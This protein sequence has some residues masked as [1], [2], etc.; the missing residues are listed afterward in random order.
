MLLL[1]G[2][3]VVL[4]WITPC[5][6]ALAENFQTNVVSGVSVD[7]TGFDYVVGTS[8]SFNYFEINGGGSQTNDD[9]IVGDQSTASNNSVVIKDNNSLWQ[10]GGNLYVGNTGS[11][12]QVTIQ[13]GGRINCVLG[14]IGNDPAAASNKVVVSDANSLWSNSQTLT[15][16][17][18]GSCNQL[19]VTNGGRVTSASGVQSSV[20][21]NSSGAISNTVLLSGSN[22][23]WNCGGPLIV[24]NGGAGSRLTI[25]SGARVRNAD[26][27]I[28]RSSTSTNNVV[29]V[30]GA[31]SLWSNTGSLIVGVSG[32]GNAVT[33]QNGGMVSNVVGHL[34]FNSS[35]GTNTV[36][37]TDANSLWFTRDKLV[38]GN[39]GGGNQL[40]IT[41]SGLVRGTNVVVG[42]GSGGNHLD[43]L[44]GQLIV[45]N[46]SSKAT[47]SI[48]GGTVT[49]NGGTVTVDQ[50]I[51]T[52]VAVGPSIRTNM[53]VFSNGSL[54]TKGTVVTDGLPFIVGDGT[55]AATL[56]LLGGTHSFAN[57]LTISSNSLL[58][59]FG[60]IAANLTNAGAIS[61]GNPVGQLTI[62]GNFAQPSNAVLNFDLGGYTQGTQ[63]DYLNA[64]GAAA[65]AGQV[66]VSF[67]NGFGATITNGSSF[68][69]LT[70]GPVTGA[71]ANAPNGSRLQT[72][73][74]L[75]DFLVTYFG[76]AFVLS[77]YHDLRDSV[78]DGIPNWWRQQYFGSAMTTNS[79]SC[80]ACDP[81]GD[82]L[83]DLQEFLAGTDPNNGASSFRV[84][85]IVRTNNDVRISWMTG[86]GKTNALQWT[87]GDVSGS[88]NTSSF[89]DIFLVT[90]TVGT[91]T[92]YLDI[93]GATIA[94]AGFY[95]V[96]L[97][98]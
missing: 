10:N 66:S 49:L 30:T 19:I 52:N 34:G 5:S 56:N 24:G 82:G 64:L 95:R 50:L 60:T 84:T 96:R 39:N 71:F 36:L 16:G 93:G 45:T 42:A 58:T 75:G 78:G 25:D 89:V 14:F 9:G 72:T 28:G 79:A 29:V 2:A 53:F 51:V 35:G 38:I 48:L 1:F 77:N 37:V 27:Q 17:A 80:A 57:G 54:N 88:Y 63:Y 7:L 47:L 3:L 86:P 94:P 85:S 26:G 68:V 83:S 92:N 67:I 76:S 81:D 70:G 91:T 12:N 98:P 33:I 18:G 32:G 62:A 21:G 55:D 15:I 40:T 8:G 4:I 97:V 44:G 65:L 41:N 73:D 20:V 74:V 13:T 23:L 90:N 61:P 6:R 59:G 31:N 11:V 46:A 22:S 87:A 69:L 43:V